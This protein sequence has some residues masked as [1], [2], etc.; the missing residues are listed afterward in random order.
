MPY[1]DRV[2]K[3]AY[4]RQ[5]VAKRKARRLG[6]IR[7]VICGGYDGVQ[8]HH[9]DKSTKVSHRM[10]SWS[11]TRIEAELAKCDFRCQ[12]CHT[13]Y[14]AAER[15]VHYDHGSNLRYTKRGCRCRL[16]K[17]AHA[18]AARDYRERRLVAS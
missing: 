3:Q 8:P 17:T 12:S 15:R 16:C 4:Q 6:G 1:A 18:E 11:W 13:D 14:H 2:V 10:W 7:C 9:R 5:W